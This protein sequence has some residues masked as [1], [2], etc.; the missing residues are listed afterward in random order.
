[1]SERRPDSRRRLGQWGENLAALHLEA[2]GLAL[3]ERNWRCR[4]GEI[5]L[6]A[7]D[8]ETFVF[9]EVKTRRGRKFGAPEEALTPHK[10]QKLLQLGQNYMA[11]HEL[12]NVNWRIDLVAVELDENGHLLR[13]DHIPNAVM[14]W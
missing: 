2:Q 4:D 11:E 6:V 7:R 13:C 14:G 1:M 9:V 10:A 8:G 3:I 5:D 12:D